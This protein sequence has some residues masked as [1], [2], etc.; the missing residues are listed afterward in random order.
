M[1]LGL[2]KYIHAITDQ[3]RLT[4]IYPIAGSGIVSFFKNWFNK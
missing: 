2:K 4:N 3:S 1:V